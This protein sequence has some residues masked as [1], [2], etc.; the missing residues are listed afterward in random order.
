MPCALVKSIERCL[1]QLILVSN[2]D[3]CTLLNLSSN[4]QKYTITTRASFKLFVSS[5]RSDPTFSNRTFELYAD[6]LLKCIAGF[7][8]VSISTSE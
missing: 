1:I 4:L 2:S 5:R 6:L 7:T 8:R 3:P